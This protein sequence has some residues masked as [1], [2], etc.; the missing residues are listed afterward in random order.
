M[1]Q[2]DSIKNRL[3]NWFYTG[4]GVVFLTLAKIKHMKGYTTPRPFPV[5]EIAKAIDY[6][7][8]VVDRWMSFLENYVGSKVSLSGKHILE[9]GPGADLGVG[10]YLLAKGA[11]R[12]SAFDAHN[13]VDTAPSEFYDAL[14]DRIKSMNSNQSSVE[15]VEMSELTSN[16]S[17][18]RLN[19]VCREDFDLL[20]AFEEKSVDLVFSQAAFEHF[21]DVDNTFSQLAKIVRPGATLVSEIDLQTHSRWIRQKDPNNIYRYNRKLYKLFKF[22]GIPNRLRPYQYVQ[23]LQRHGWTDIRVFPGM[24]LDNARLTKILPFMSQEYRNDHSQMHYLTIILCA[25]KA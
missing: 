17:S 12:Y 13:L 20:K 19:Y 23:S 5:S 14:G 16:S 24:V 9:L 8:R 25:K 10:M 4:A 3:E 1:D 11:A 15:P 21:D 22:K 2:F 7:I 6:D 18:Q